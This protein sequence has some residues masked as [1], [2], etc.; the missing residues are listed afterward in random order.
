MVMEYLEGSDLSGLIASAGPLPIED[1]VDFVLQAC[2]A[3]AEAHS[4]GIVHRDLKPGNLFLVRRADGSRVVKVLDF[5]ISKTTGVLGAGGVKTSTA[6]MMGS[7]LYMSPEQLNSAR[8]VDVRA[9][10]WSLGI[11]LFEL[12]TGKLP[13]SGG[14]I[15]QLCVA[16]M[17]APALRAST[18]RP[19]VPA[20]LEAIVARCIEKDRTQRYGNIADLSRALLDFAPARSSV[21]VERV[22][23]VL[24]R[25]QMQ[26]P[27]MPASA[28]PGSTTGPRQETVLVPEDFSGLAPAPAAGTN[29]AWGQ[30]AR[31]KGAP[32]RRNLVLTLAGIGLAG[33]GLTVFGLSRPVSTATSTGSAPI[34]SAEA[35]T[36][37]PSAPVAKVARPMPPEPDP[38]AERNSDAPAP[39]TSSPY[40]VLPPAMRNPAFPP[41]SPTS[42]GA[43]PS[44]GPRSGARPPLP[45]PAPSFPLRNKALPGSGLD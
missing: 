19:D 1:A 4:L 21:S 16:I 23:H 31:T 45:P 14:S 36:P 34:P 41:A 43:R 30:T 6:V 37:E 40:A 9:D 2:E 12:L 17:H 13:F 20:G 24:S 18:L 35:P 10:I 7:P 39:S 26:S 11:I 29:P 44:K 3:V 42:L 22:T 28:F 33:V 38:S 15:P 32:G 25:S 8:D 27:V 5:G